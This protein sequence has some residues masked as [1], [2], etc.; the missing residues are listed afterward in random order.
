MKEKIK[1]IYQA[2]DGKLVGKPAL[3]ALVCETLLNFP[4]E[5]V[6]FVTKNIWFLGSTEDAWAFTI[7]G[8]EIKNNFLILVN[9][10]LLQQPKQHGYFTIAHEIGHVSLGH[11]NSIQAVQTQSEIAI[12]EQEANGFAEKYLGPVA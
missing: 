7:K 12:Q 8:Q 4:D 10:E 2:F 3:K 1:K 6:S 5:I 9:D 11:R